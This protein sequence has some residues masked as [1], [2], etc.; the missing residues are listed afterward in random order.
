MQKE[1]I[2]FNDM[3]RAL[4]YLVDKVELLVSILKEQ[5]KASE[6]EPGKKWMNLDELCEYLPGKPSKTTVYGWV[7]QRAIPYHKI[8]RRLSFL[9]SEIDE[10]I[11][12]SGHATAEDIQEAAIEKYS[13]R[14]G[15][16]R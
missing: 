8:T 13:Y 2:T 16:L 3:P 12:R 10:W 1:D 5:R 6:P 4:A 7:C 15:G 11:S 14:K 9:K